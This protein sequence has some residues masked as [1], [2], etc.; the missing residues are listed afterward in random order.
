MDG[1]SWPDTGMGT[2]QGARALRARPVEEMAPAIIVRYDDI[3]G[4]NRGGLRSGEADRVSVFTSVVEFGA[5]NRARRVEIPKPDDFRLPGTHYCTTARRGRFRL[6]RKG[7]QTGQQDPGAHRRGAPQALAPRLGRSLGRVLVCQ[8]NRQGASPPKQNG[9]VVDSGDGQGLERPISD[10]GNI[11]GSFLAP[12]QSIRAFFRQTGRGAHDAS[13]RPAT[14]CE[15]GEQGS[16]TVA[17]ERPQPAGRPAKARADQSGKRATG[18]G[19]DTCGEKPEGVSP[20]SFGR[21]APGVP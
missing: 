14:T 16:A 2:P 19:P 4:S 7:R 13:M 1:G 10:E 8:A 9:A 6:G 3:S 18:G 20:R 15:G 11:A 17:E 21:A 5:P 12:L